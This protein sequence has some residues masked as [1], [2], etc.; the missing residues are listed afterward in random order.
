MAINNLSAANYLWFDNQVLD[1]TQP[2]TLFSAF[3]CTVN[4]ATRRTHIGFGSTANSN[5]VSLEAVSQTMRFSGWIQGGVV[6]SSNTFSLTDWNFTSASYRATNYKTIYLNG[7]KTVTTVANTAP[8][9]LNQMSIGVI[10]RTSGGSNAN[11]ASNTT[12]AEQAV[13][14]VEL[15]DDEHMALNHGCSPLKIRP[16]SLVYYVPAVKSPVNLIGEPAFNQGAV[17]YTISD[18]P[19]MYY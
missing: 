9:V 15:T 6:V 3:K 2:Y 1:L 12:L 17:R 11:G 19:P 8:L 10:R 13:W 5:Y 16:E 14:N 7:V 4:N 18:H